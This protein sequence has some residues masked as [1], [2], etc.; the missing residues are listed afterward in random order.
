M[1]ENL[2]FENLVVPIVL[3]IVSNLLTFVSTKTFYKNFKTTFFEF[4]DIPL[5][6]KEAWKDDAVTKEEIIFVANEIKEFADS[7]ITLKKVK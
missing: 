1:F 6:I 7:L 2:D 3:L 5:A 4:C